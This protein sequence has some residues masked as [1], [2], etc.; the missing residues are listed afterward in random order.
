M[1]RLE[2]SLSSPRRISKIKDDLVSK[3]A[4]G[5][6][7]TKR[8]DHCPVIP[9]TGIRKIVAGRKN[10]NPDVRLAR[11]FG[12]CEGFFLCRRGTMT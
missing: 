2:F 9:N 1:E 6:A 4:L 3:E 12:V 10:A 5:A 8:P 11:Y 7:I